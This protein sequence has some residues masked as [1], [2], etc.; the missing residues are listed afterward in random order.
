AAAEGSIGAELAKAAEVRDIVCK[1]AVLVTDDTQVL[2]ISSLKDGTHYA[3]VSTDE[4]LVRMAT[5]YWDSPNCC[6]C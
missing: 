2:T 3:I 1:C 4:T 6:E 5:E